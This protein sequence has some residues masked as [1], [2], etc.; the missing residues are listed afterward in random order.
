LEQKTLEQS[1]AVRGFSSF[2][3]QK[4]THIKKPKDQNRKK[5]TLSR[6]CQYT[7]VGAGILMRLFKPSNM[8]KLSFYSYN[9]IT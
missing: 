2:I 1:E 9:Y 5:A 7:Y 3:K 6:G 4:G 8:I